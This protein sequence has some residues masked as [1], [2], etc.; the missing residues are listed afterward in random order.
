MA[1]LIVENGLE[2]L[3][4]YVV[5]SSCTDVADVTAITDVAVGR[6][7]QASKIVVI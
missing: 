2:C 4:G 6:G 1:Y 5:A 3:P 7:Q